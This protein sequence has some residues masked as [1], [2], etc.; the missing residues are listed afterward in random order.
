MKWFVLLIALAGGALAEGL[1]RK[2]QPV[3]GPATVT[4]GEKLARLDV[5][6]GMLFLGR[7]DTIHVL[8]RAGNPTDGSEIG[9]VHPANPTDKFFIVIEHQ[10]IGHIAD[11]DLLD[12]DALMASVVKAQGEQNEDRKRRALTQIT[13]TG[14][15][16][17]P[18]YDHP[19]K[20]MTWAVK[21]KSGKEELVNYRT[22]LLG[23]DGFLS[24]NL[25]TDPAAFPH[26]K[27][28]VLGVLAGTS[29]LPGARY[30]DYQPGKDRE[31]G[32][33]LGDLVVGGGPGSGSPVGSRWLSSMTLAK[34]LKILAGVAVALFVLVRRSRRR[35]GHV[36][37]VSG[38]HST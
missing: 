24:F 16:E 32:C 38:P 20:R 33:G 36:V 22:R 15:A 30:E 19:T 9:L 34:G 11:D 18:R 35:R 4:L 31:S 17:P 29:Y 7:D 14:W 3:P 6:A 37:S 2:I 5:P 25:V 28:A 1:H 27:K 21:A 26:D 13:I 8:R 23:R 12:L 10:P